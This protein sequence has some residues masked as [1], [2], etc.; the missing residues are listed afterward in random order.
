[1][2]AGCGMRNMQEKSTETVF[3]RTHQDPQRIQRLALQILWQGIPDDW[4]PHTA[5][6]DSYGRERA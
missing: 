2:I 4:K 5:R 6:K 3:D 1:M